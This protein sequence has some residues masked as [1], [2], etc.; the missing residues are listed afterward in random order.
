MCGMSVRSSFTLRTRG[1]ESLSV[2]LQ[3]AVSTAAAVTAGLEPW[4]DGLLS[5]VCCC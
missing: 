4:S 5:C 3:V 1:R 2:P